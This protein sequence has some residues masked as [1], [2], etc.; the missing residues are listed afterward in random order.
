MQQAERRRA[1]VVVTGAGSGIGLDAARAFHAR[2]DAVVLVGRDPR[3]LERAV[4]ALGGGERAAAVA[5]N[6]ADRAT[7]DAL[8]RTAVERF[9]GID[10][11][12]NSA[13][14]FATRPFLDVAEEE[15][16]GFLVG[17][18]KA[19][20]LTTQA[21]VRR[22]RD[23]GRG[24][25]VVSVGTVLV[26]HGD[27]GLPCSAPIVSKGGI[28]ALTVS[29]AAELAP[30]QIRVNLVAPGVIRTPLWGDGDVDAART[31]AALDRV[32]EVDDTTAAIL[33]LADAPFVTGHVLRVD[34]GYVTARQ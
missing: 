33:Y 5:G 22:M 23:Q 28:H 15:L 17:N 30:H 32:G 13:G 25:A 2:G 31:A 20:Y 3:K 7:R 16:D 14:T 10:V 18:L 11:L 9:G 8:V 12:V 24:G 29:L 4:A 1:T 34:G 6:T 21:V 19:T 27:S 26:E